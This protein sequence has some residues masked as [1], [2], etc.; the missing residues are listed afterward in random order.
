MAV[1]ILRVLHR[2]LE[3]RLP[4]REA[5]DGEGR[6]ERL[7]GRPVAGLALSLRLHRHEADARGVAGVDRGPR[8]GSC[9]TR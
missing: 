8:S 2:D 5:A 4:R 3:L 6:Q 7:L 1:A 9:I